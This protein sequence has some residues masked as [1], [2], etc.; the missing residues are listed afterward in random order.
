MLSHVDY[1]HDMIELIACR[2]STMCKTR[3]AQAL[4]TLSYMLSKRSPSCCTVRV[5][6]ELITHSLGIRF[7]AV[8]D[9]LNVQV[10]MVYTV[11]ISSAVFTATSSK[12][13][14]LFV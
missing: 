14:H 7:E 6:T 10:L 2:H 1:C 9:S 13:W 3:L 4:I 11:G 12:A 8:G 5:E